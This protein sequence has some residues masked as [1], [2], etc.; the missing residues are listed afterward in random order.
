MHN[1]LKLYTYCIIANRK[2]NANLSIKTVNSNNSH[3][4]FVIDENI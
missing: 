4:C 2:P 1:H 3:S